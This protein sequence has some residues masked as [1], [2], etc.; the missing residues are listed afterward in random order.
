M[1][2]VEALT[3]VFDL[4]EVKKF[5]NAKKGFT[6][7]QN[8]DILFAK[9]TPCME[10]GKIVIINGLKNGIGFGSTEFHIIRLNNIFPNKYIFY[11]LL[12]DSFRKNAERNMT[13]SA[14]QKR[15]P[16]DYLKNSI[17]PLPPLPEQ[18]RIVAR[19]EELFSK[20]DAGVK[21]LEEA[22]AQ[23][24]RYRQ[25]VLKSAV[26]G[27]LTAKWRDTHRGELE[28]AEKLLERIR[29]E[30]K[31][32]LGKKYKEPESIDT[33]D[34]PQLPEGWM[35]TTLTHLG[36]WSGGGT[37][38]K[39]KLQYWNGGNIPWVSPKDMKVDFIRD[40]DD[41]ITLTAI[42]ESSTKIIPEMSL[43]FVTRSGILRRF[44]PIAINIIPVTVNQDIKALIVHHP[45][46]PNYLLFTMQSYNKEIL[47]TC[48]KDG[49]TVQSIES[50]LLYNYVVPIPPI[51]EQNIII[52]K[53]TQI[54]SIIDE[55]ERVIKLELK[56][57]KSL[58]QSILK[59]AFEGKLVPQDPNDEPASVLLE[60]IKK[61]KMDK[62]SR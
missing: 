56:R 16:A 36:T 17:I 49:T 33:S 22:K 27:K 2:K 47:H 50:Q 3:G 53:V 43:L 48:S 26:E 10:N 35:W 40:T 39:S 52:E 21:S 5:G 55:S 41:H 32:K 7:F 37:P 4:S 28:P 19:I 60:R 57:A 13:G 20:L 38:S 14:G 34:L 58:R 15:V 18:H 6:S 44:L 59:R 42:K 61:Q 9:I 46:N 31:A 12:Q 54:L 1:K 25:S 23:L 30:R 24:K 29:A 45:I 62:L 11:F 51:K 8:N